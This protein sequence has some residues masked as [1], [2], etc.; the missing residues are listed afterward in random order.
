MQRRP[1]P[2]A[3]RLHA[4]CAGSSGR[5]WL[6]A[7]GCRT[8]SMVAPDGPQRT[9][10][11]L[12]L[13]SERCGCAGRAW[14]GGHAARGSTARPAG[15]ARCGGRRAGGRRG[16]GDR[17]RGARPGSKAVG[18]PTL[19]LCPARQ[20]SNGA[21]HHG[22]AWLAARTSCTM[23]R[24]VISLFTTCPSAQRGLQPFCLDSPGQPLRDPLCH[25]QQA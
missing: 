19:S 10:G 25:R 22:L 17:M 12:A 14:H 9:S 11:H 24:I 23:Q 8:R 18:H 2:W 13:A 15:R 7:T 21:P 4:T 3:C 5:N 1:W 16:A 20:Q 6:R